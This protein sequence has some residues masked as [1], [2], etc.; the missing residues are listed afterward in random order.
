MQTNINSTMRDGGKVIVSATFT[1]PENEWTPE[2]AERVV[3]G[4]SASTPGSSL[5]AIRSVKIDAAQAAM[6]R[7]IGID[8]ATFLKYSR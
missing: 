3:R 2:E 6:N 5:A 7:K 8:D 1:F 4:F